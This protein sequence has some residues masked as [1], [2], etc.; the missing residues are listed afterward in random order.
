MFDKNLDELLDLL[1]SGEITEET[2][3]EECDVSVI[4][5][6]LELRI[7]CCLEKGDKYSAENIDNSLLYKI[8]SAEQQKEI[9][10]MGRDIGSEIVQSIDR[11]ELTPA[12]FSDDNKFVTFVR[13]HKYLLWVLLPKD[14]IKADE[15]A[16]EMYNKLLA[17]KHYFADET[18][19]ER[20]KELFL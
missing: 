12:M 2:I 16:R 20:Y 9:L 8:L 13:Y 6:V 14:P 5:K 11:G 7:N 4:S 17:D 18:L 19:L 15:L 10:K 3:A 1:E